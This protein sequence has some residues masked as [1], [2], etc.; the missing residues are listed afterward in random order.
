[1]AIHNAVLFDSFA[2]DLRVEVLEGLAASTE[3]LIDFLSILQMI[4]I[5]NGHC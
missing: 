1:M 5:C 2:A 3:V 4:F